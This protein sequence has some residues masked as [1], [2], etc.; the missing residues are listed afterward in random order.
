MIEL[1]D[2]D[3]FPVA[4][5]VTLQTIGS[6][7]AVV[8]VLMT[9]STAGRNSKKC[10]GY[11]LDLDVRAFVLRDM[12]WRVTLVTLQPDVFSF[13]FPVG[14]RV[15]EM[16]EVPFCQGEVFAIVLGVAGNTFQTR[17]RLEVV[18]SVQTFSHLDA[19][20]NFGMAIQALESGFS[21]REFMAGGAVGEAVDRLVSAGKR[22]GRNLGRCGHRGRQESQKYPPKKSWHRD[23]ANSLH[24]ALI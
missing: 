9:G 12:F 5:V 11:V 13:E 24:E 23:G 6:E 14:L 22:A 17:A 19:P 16:L 15:I 20:G 21:G 2:A 3:G 4:G 1:T 10:P 7:A 8:L 18:G